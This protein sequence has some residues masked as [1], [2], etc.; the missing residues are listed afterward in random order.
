MS[1]PYGCQLKN[2]RPHAGAEEAG[3]EPRS[4]SSNCRVTWLGRVVH[5]AQ[6]LP[7]VLKEQLAALSEPF[8]FGTC[9]PAK[10]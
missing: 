6:G 5:S 1:R 9:G 7:F 4:S 10:A 2:P 8:R 3:A